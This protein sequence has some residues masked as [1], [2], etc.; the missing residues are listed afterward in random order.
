MFCS[1]VK[2]IRSNIPLLLIRHF[3]TFS[4]WYEWTATGRIVYRKNF[5]VL[6]SSMISRRQPLLP[7][8][9]EVFHCSWNEE[10]KGRSKSVHGFFDEI[11]FQCGSVLMNSSVSKKMK[12]GFHLRWMVP[13]TLLNQTLFTF[14]QPGMFNIHFFTEEYMRI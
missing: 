7:S 1:W 5:F 8:C 14:Y 9:R 13:N 6:S 4:Q 12:D 11:S 2:T 10:T 3:S